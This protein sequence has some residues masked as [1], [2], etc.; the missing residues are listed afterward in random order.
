MSFPEN[1]DQLAV[2]AWIDRRFEVRPQ[3][4]APAV[5][6]RWWLHILLFVLT[7]MVATD[8]TIGGLEPHVDNLAH[9]GGFF[10]G[11]LIAMVLGPRRKLKGSS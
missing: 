4:R 10:A 7:L 3:F 6:R 2:P 11:I 9:V 1:P 8:F 5:A